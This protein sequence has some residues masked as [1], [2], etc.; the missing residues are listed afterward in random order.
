VSWLQVTFSITSKNVSRA[1]ELLIQAHA[2]AVTLE[3]L[4]DE[5]VLEPDPGAIP[6]WTRIRLKALF[7]VDTD[8]PALR[9]VLNKIDPNIHKHLEVDFIGEEDWQLRML[10]HAVDAKFGR[11]LWLKPKSSERPEAQSPREDSD[12]TYLFLD[13]GLA[14]GSG[15]HPTTRMC[16]EWIAYN[17]KAQQRVLDFG[18][19][20]GILAIGAALLGAQVVAVDHD[21]QAV[22][23]T[24]ENAE[25]NHVANRVNALSLNQWQ[26]L[27]A[28]EAEG[29]SASFDVLVANI[30][31][32][33]LISFAD[34]FAALLKRS[35]HLV[36][37]G[38]LVDQAEDVIAAYPSVRF[39]P[40]LVEEQWVCLVGTS[41]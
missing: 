13:P 3:S 11:R 19:G 6:M 25:F 1:E 36:L 10:N 41:L 20:S 16:L 26:H 35:G 4:A 31:A 40:P 24:N 2:S 23:A 9:A 5:V 21:D 12:Q 7:P 39:D 38:V 33:P 37:S 8:V 18:C 28:S 27:S 15:S 34:E 29:Y 17:L 14:F 22:L 30:L 32:A